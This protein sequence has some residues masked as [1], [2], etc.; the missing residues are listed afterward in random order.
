MVVVASSHDDD[1][2]VR[3][4]HAYLMRIISRIQIRWLWT[5]MPIEP[6]GL[7]LWTVTAAGSL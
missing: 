7:R 4:F 3:R 1:R 2:L 6:S 5:S